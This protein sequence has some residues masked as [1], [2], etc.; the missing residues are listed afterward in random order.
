MC[1]CIC[2]HL[3]SKAD[4]YVPARQDLYTTHDANMSDYATFKCQYACNSNQGCVSFFGRFANVS[5]DYEH[6]ECVSLSSL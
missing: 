2:L 3:Q 1:V 4:R 6:F 5:T